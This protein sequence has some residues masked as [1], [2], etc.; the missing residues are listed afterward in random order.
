MTP[1]SPVAVAVC[2]SA[3]MSIALGCRPG[4]MGFKAG[5]LH[6]RQTT[7]QHQMLMHCQILLNDSSTPSAVAG[8]TGVGS[9]SCMRK[10]R[11]RRTA[12]PSGRASAAG[13]F[14]ARGHSRANQSC[15]GAIGKFLTVVRSG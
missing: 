8:R 6:A 11:D 1:L 5:R 9:L 15:I 4:G 10:K 12:E 7:E 14:V 3:L 13:A 2:G